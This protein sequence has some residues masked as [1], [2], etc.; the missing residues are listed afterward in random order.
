MKAA[1]KIP[2]GKGDNFFGWNLWAGGGEA[3]NDA[4]KEN[5][6]NTHSGAAAPKLSQN[7]FMQQNSTR[8]HDSHQ[9]PP[10]ASQ[11]S[12]AAGDAE[13]RRHNNARRVSSEMQVEN[14]C[15]GACSL[16]AQH[17]RGVPFSVLSVCSGSAEVT[18]IGARE[19]V[20]LI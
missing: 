8:M 18:A 17:M 15:V 7:P 14:S 16:R 5:R 6:G 20:L 13:G 12:S 3:S 9:T 4:G 19:V 10:R 2:D 11:A 1:N